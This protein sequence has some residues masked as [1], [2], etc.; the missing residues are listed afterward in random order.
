M[1]NR[2]NLKIV[3]SLLLFFI[4]LFACKTTV[5]EIDI[6]E[7]DT[8]QN[9][10]DENV[11]PDETTDQT[12]VIDTTTD[13]NQFNYQVTD[14]EYSEV[15]E[16][17]QRALL[18][19]ADKYDATN[20]NRANELLN[21]SQNI[22][23]TDGNAARTLLREAKESAELAYRNTYR[24]RAVEM[25]QKCDTLLDSY[26]A[27]VKNFSE[28][29]TYN[30]ATALY[31]E[32]DQRF[33]E[34]NFV[35]SFNS[36]SS[37]AE[38]IELVVNEI[39][40][41]REEMLVRIDFV[42]QLIDKAIEM[43]GREH[44]EEYIIQAQQRL[45]NGIA[46]YS[47]LDYDTAT[48]NLDAAETSANEAIRITLAA[49]R[50]L[51]RQEALRAIMEAAQSLSGASTTIIIDENGEKYQGDRFNFDLNLPDPAVNYTDINTNMS[52]RD[53]FNQAV[54]YLHKAR[55]SYL[56]DDF[57]MAIEYA[58]IAQRLAAAY[59]STGVRTTY[60]VQLILQ[61]RDCLWRIA[62]YSGIYSDPFLWPVI[63][64]A[65]K[66][67][68]YNPDLIFPGQILAIPDID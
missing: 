28:T 45:E 19:G 65:N 21:Q 35:G 44:A 17:I 46:D 53:I 22:N 56:E 12:V 18:A 9:Q 43:N 20:F 40:K 31:T 26:R 59:R 7:P 57:D 49:L 50:E 2:L 24:L 5:P 68:I 63:W 55:D 67:D 4:Y 10:T 51:R 41:N 38:K 54:N 25:K 3:F 11:N 8:N 14:T 42:R 47:T 39:N 29:N 13:Q 1:K 48:A 64:R 66:K 58:R 15:R 16:V 52:F 6:D 34:E 32:G 60:T 62:E 30:E 36:F 37:C 33:G 27:I 61:R 23:S